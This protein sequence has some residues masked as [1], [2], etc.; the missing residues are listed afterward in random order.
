V[1]EGAAVGGC[2]FL[3]ALGRDAALEAVEGQEFL[4]LLVEDLEQADTPAEV[5]QLEGLAFRL[6]DDGTSEGQT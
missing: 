4:A 1:E 6:R 2:D 5:L 3:G